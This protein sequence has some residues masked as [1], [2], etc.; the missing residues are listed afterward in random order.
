V[1][2]ACRSVQVLNPMTY[3]EAKAAALESP[4]GYF[5]AKD[6]VHHKPARMPGSRDRKLC[7]DLQ[8]YRYANHQAKAIIRRVNQKNPRSKKPLQVWE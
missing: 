7:A 5:S 1:V 2:F 4:V 6:A 8:R 3:E